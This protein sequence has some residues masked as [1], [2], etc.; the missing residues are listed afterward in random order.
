VTPLQSTSSLPGD[1]ELSRDRLIDGS[2]IAALRASAPAGITLRTDEE[3]ERSLERT[4]KGHASGAD[5]HVFGYGSLMWN[6]AFR[7][8]DAA[9]ARVRGWRRSFC[10]WLRMARGSPSKP[11]LMLALDRGGSC[12]GVVFRIPAASVR[13]ELM[14]LWR[15]EM[16]S[17]AY[18]ARWITALVEGRPRRALTFVAN[19]AH[20]RYVPD[21]RADQVAHFISTGEGSLG[22]CAAYFEKMMA[23]LA[24]LEIRDAGMERVGVA[25]SGRPAPCA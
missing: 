11:G 1:T 12:G 21:L 14:L 5:I 7:H 9:K 18:E 2:L 16:L 25:L 3:L 6:P 17:G 13:Y 4:L 24:H 23:A 10:L 22:T 20:E 15:R 19:R 8:V